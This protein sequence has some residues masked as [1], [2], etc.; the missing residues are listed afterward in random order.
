M[1]FRLPQNLSTQLN[2]ERGE[3]V[4]AYEIMAEKAASLGRA[5][6]TIETALAKLQNFAGPAAEHAVL[7][8]S[9]AD[10]VHAFL[11]QR[12]LCGMMQHDDAIAHYRVPREILAK[13]G[14][15]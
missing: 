15:K 6:K 8:Q 1:T 11:I 12:E 13:M 4:L 3:S 14:V 7:V 10:A 2:H 9:A 5:G